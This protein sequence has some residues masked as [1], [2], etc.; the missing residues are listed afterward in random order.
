MTSDYDWGFSPR[1]TLEKLARAEVKI[2]MLEAQVAVLR[3]L[4]PVSTYSE[5]AAASAPLP[6]L[7]L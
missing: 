1:E 5:R 6:S 7:A 3:C 4:A 2:A